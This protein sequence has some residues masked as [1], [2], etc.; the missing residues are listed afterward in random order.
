M[1]IQLYCSLYNRLFPFDD[2]RYCLRYGL[3][4]RYTVET[5]SFRYFKMEIR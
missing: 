3:R 1:R 2:Y 5:F 4:Y